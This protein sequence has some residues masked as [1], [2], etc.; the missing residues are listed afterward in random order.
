MHDETSL[1]EFPRTGGVLLG[2]GGFFDGVVFHQLLQ[3]HHMLSGPRRIARPVE[4]SFAPASVSGSGRFVT[5][6]K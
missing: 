1:R 2:L 5:V 4:S 6:M 3:W